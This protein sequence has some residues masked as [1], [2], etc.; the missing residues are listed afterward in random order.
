MGSS[1]VWSLPDFEL[2]LHHWLLWVYGAYGPWSLEPGV[3]WPYGQGL[4][5]CATQPLIL[6]SFYMKEELVLCLKTL[7]ST[8]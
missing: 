5:S 4:H 1:W 8:Q 6:L 2:E 3:L 7:A